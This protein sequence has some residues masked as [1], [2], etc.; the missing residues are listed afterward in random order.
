M[1]DLIVKMKGETINLEKLKF[2]VK[3]FLAGHSEAN[4]KFETR[5]DDL[6][7]SMVIRI[8]NR[9]VRR[10]IRKKEGSGVSVS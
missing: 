6:L 9:S 2:S 7:D 4:L 1:K 8:E 5:V 3:R 10:K